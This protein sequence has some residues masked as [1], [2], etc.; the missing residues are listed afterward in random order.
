VGRWHGRCAVEPRASSESHN[1][2]ITGS[3]LTSTLD[4][5]V[6]A[7]DHLARERYGKNVLAL[8]LRWILDQGPTVGREF[9]APPARAAAD[10]GL[11]SLRS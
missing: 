10:G 2:R 4:D 1:H 11:V 8:A 6:A 5:A 7:L 9:M 3:A